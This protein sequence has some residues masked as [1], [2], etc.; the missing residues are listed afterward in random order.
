M[1]SFYLLRLIIIEDLMINN[2]IMIIENMSHD[3]VI[4]I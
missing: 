2:S 3:H 4:I 1:I